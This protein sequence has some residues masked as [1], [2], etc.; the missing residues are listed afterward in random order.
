MHHGWLLHFIIQPESIA[1]CQA[2]V[3]APLHAVLHNNVDPAGVAVAR[4]GQHADPP[5]N[6]SEALKEFGNR[7]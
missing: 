6:T 2:T 7:E 5:Q 3:K 1:G 4:T